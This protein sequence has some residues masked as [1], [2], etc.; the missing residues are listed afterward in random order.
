MPSAMPSTPPP[1]PDEAAAPTSLVLQRAS[2]RFQQLLGAGRVLE[3]STRAIEEEADEL[4]LELEA[5][6]ERPAR[7]SALVERRRER[8]EEQRRQDV[9]VGAAIAEALGGLA[10]RLSPEALQELSDVHV[11]VVEVCLALIQG[12][13]QRALEAE[14]S[15][16]DHQV[17][18]LERRLAKMVEALHRAEDALRR[19]RSLK[20]VDEGIASVYRVVQGLDAHAEDAGRKKDLLAAIF[21]ANVELREQCATASASGAATAQSAQSTGKLA[22]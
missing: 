20:H 5:L 15:A 13:R 7:E 16:H 14:V 8:V 3:H 9:V 21:A 18:Q 4:V 10:G 22:A 6:R 11:R 1:A 12:E 19:V 17:E 2:E